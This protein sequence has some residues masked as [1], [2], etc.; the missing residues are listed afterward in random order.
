M[1]IKPLL[2]GFASYIPWLY[3]FASKGTGGTISARYCYSVWLRHLSIAH[4]NGLPTKPDTIAEL[5]PGDSL[6]IGLA[7]LISGA[8]K[9]YAFDVVKYANNKRNTEIFDELVNLFKKRERIPDEAEFPLV[10]PYLKSY[11]F[12]NHIL[13]DKR[14]NQ[15]LKQDRIE[16]LRNALLNLGRKNN[17]NIISYLV[18]WHDSYI[19]KKE[20]V[21]MIYSQAVLEHINDLTHTYNALYHWLN[22]GG[23]MSHQIDFKCHGTAKKWNGHWAYSDFTW[24]LIKGKKSYILNRKPHST[25]INLLRKFGFKVVC[26][27]KIND[28]TGIQRK[29]LSSRFKNISD[30]DLTTSGAFIQ[31]LKN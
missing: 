9:Y 8:N 23:F 31:A 16:Y 4:K 3:K 30:D 15:A 20:S 1:R 21:D 19:I 18:P 27:I 5:G 28:A 12:P 11:E 22:H 17:G 29:Y 7:A 24:K 14:L 25:H 6:G 26:D 13:T 2:I 10:K